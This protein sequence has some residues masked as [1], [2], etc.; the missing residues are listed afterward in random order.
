MA[1]KKRMLGQFFTTNPAI[2]EQLVSLVKH[3]NPVVLEPSAGAG[4]LMEAVRNHHP[5]ATVEGWELD[6]DIP[7][8]VDGISYGDFFV[9]A[10]G[11]TP[12]TT[13]VSN[14][15]FVRFRDV[16]PST[17][18]AAAKV[19]K[20][21]GDKVNLY[22]LF[23]HRCADLLCDGGEMI[24]IVPSE[25]MFSPTAQ[26]LR[27]HL[28]THGHVTHIVSIGGEKVFDDADLPS[29]MIMRYVKSPAEDST[30]VFYKDGL[31]S[32]WDRRVITTGGGTWACITPELLKSITTATHTVG[33]VASVKVGMVT[34]ADGVFR[35]PESSKLF[36][37][38]NTE[39]T[40]IPMMTPR[41]VEHYINVN[42]CDDI[43]DIPPHTREYLLE[44]K[45]SLLGRRIAVFTE[46][47][48]W[49]YGAIR[50][51]EAMSG[52][53]ARIFVASR[54]RRTS[55]FFI[56]SP[57]QWFSASILGVFPHDENDSGWLCDYLNS[58]VFYDVAR[59][60]GMVTDNR[61]SLGPTT[62]S[63][64]PIVER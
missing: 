6:E 62:L 35:I 11:A 8:I 43:A 29:L 22:Q 4:H 32:P 39:G 37:L 17:A 57:T 47:N 36:P 33:D 7:A 20:H 40:L 3:P 44:H 1:D 59:A 31:H 60:H 46:D 13:I 12:Y 58:D 54:T 41:G 64:L 38:L 23:M 53:D 18:Q 45:K 24:V 27:E 16:S 14:P 61:M 19:K 55:P 25:W 30:E 26:P 50:N 51:R 56:G 34:G 5:E 10:D 9:L 42:D 2:Q 28:S 63:A 52:D 48:W 49:K 15:P 21:Y